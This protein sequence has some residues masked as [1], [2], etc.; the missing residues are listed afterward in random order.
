MKKTY[1]LK[2]RN[3]LQLQQLKDLRVFHK[4]KEVNRNDLENP[5]NFP[6][7]MVRSMIR[8]SQWLEGIM[9]MIEEATH[10]LSP[11][12]FL[13]MEGEIIKIVSMRVPIY[14]HPSLY[15]ALKL[16]FPQVIGDL[17]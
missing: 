4:S 15:R 8:T 13:I 6:R 16:T 7:V 14:V 12:S 3:G 11:S 9:N 1:I 2:S 5:R 10:A 17:V